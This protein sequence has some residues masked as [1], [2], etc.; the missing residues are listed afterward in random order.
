[1]FNSPVKLN[2]AFFNHVI[3]MDLGNIC[4]FGKSC[5]TQLNFILRNKQKN[6]KNF[7]YSS[8]QCEII[9]PMIDVLCIS[10]FDC[11]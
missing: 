6:Q 10:M 7:P 9:L 2:Y 4:Y 5:I 11:V 1:M 3:K 8:S